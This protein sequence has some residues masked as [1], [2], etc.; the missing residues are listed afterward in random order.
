MQ[1]LADKNHG[2]KY[3]QGFNLEMAIGDIP[4]QRVTKGDHGYLEP[5]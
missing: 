3:V 5:K 2:K 4:R 1:K